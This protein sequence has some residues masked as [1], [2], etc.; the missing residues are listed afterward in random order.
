MCVAAAIRPMPPT[1]DRPNVLWLLAE[2]MGPELGFLGT[3]EARTPNFDRLARE[4]QY[5]EN[6]FTTSPVCSPSRSAF[7]TGT[8]QWTI[9]AH[10]H[11]SHRE[12]DPSPPNPLPEGV[13][14]VS[15]WLRDA[16]YRTGNVATFPDGVDF[17]GTAKTDWNFTYEG[18][19]FDTD[20]WADLVGADRPFYAQVNF[21]ETHQG[22]HWDTAHERIDDPADPDAVEFPPYYPDHEV[23]RETWAQ[24][25]NAVMALDRKVGTVLDLL[26]EAG[27]LEDTVVVFMPDHGRAM[28]R[29]KQ[30]PYDS[31]LH[32]PLLVRW[33][34]DHPEPDGYERG[35]VSDRLVSAVD[36]AATTLSVAGVEVPER[37]QGR[38][39][40][41]DAEEV[42]PERRFVLGGR[43]R[44][45]E[46][47]DRVRTVRTRRYRYLRNFY[48]G[49]PLLQRNRYKE[50][51]Y[52]VLWL[53]RKL[54]A[55]GDLEPEQERLLADERP[56]EELYDL[57]ED[58]H[59]V[60]NLAGD[61]AHRERLHDLREAL[62]RRLRETDDRGRLPEDPEVV[63]HYEEQ[64]RENFDEEIADIRAEW[65]L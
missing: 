24:Y 21:P 54:D 1:A 15:D 61:P 13:R 51:N 31:G 65:D 49:R 56:E 28:V 40:L 62:D 44:G 27:E 50:A 11:R 17:E 25:L 41:G 19:P 63:D 20:R 10:D 2:D 60:A 55:E 12:E 35:G 36:L 53:L 57:T 33:P 58:P 9:G 43:D 64:M 22:H 32:V 16:G 30:F 46:T 38:V 3:P 5:Y 45:D 23:T 6:A 42:D 48:P 29:G 47:V 52:P 4:G 18:E 37:M 8:Y 26:A 59:E 14:V 39:F 34:R 7:N